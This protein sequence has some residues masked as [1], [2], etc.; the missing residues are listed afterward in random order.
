MNFSLPAEKRGYIAF[1]V[2]D[3]NNPARPGS[4]R[5][6]IYYQDQTPTV[7]HRIQYNSVNKHMFG[8]TPLNND[9]SFGNKADKM[10]I[11]SFGVKVFGNLRVGPQDTTQEG[12]QVEYNAPDGSIGY[13]TDLVTGA[14][15]NPATE[16]FFRIRPVGTHTSGG[17]LIGGEGGGNSQPSIFMYTDGDVRFK[18]DSGGIVKGL[19]NDNGT[20]NS[21]A[22]FRVVSTMPA[23]PDANIIYFVV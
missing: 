6:E 9:N 17:I 2:P 20:S 3:Q 15:G 22:Q 14:N 13:I 10:E 19:W 8:V 18:I 4:L 16:A 11:N 5:G 23:T 21:N 1:S 12:G 7:N